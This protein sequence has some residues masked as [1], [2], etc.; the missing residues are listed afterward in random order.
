M[1]K[2][3]GGKGWWK[4]AALVVVLS[5]IFLGSAEPRQPLCPDAVVA[6]LDGL[7][8]RT[9]R[10]T[11]LEDGDETLAF[12]AQGSSDVDVYLYDSRGKL[13]AYDTEDLARGAVPL[14][15]APGTG[16]YAMVVNRTADAATVSLE[17]R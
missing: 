2:S 5:A 6:A 16:L 4:Q 10:L 3:A 1:T 13:I 15:D 14:G 9:Y 8:S 11:D 7:E 12:R 17:L